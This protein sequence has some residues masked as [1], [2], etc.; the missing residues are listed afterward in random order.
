[1]SLGLPCFR[2]VPNSHRDLL[3]EWDQH[4][5]NT[6]DQ[7]SNCCPVCVRVSLFVSFGVFS[8]LPGLHGDRKLF[9]REFRQSSACTTLRDKTPRRIPSLREIMADL[10]RRDAQNHFQ[11][12]HV[13]YTAAQARSVGICFSHL[14]PWLQKKVPRWSPKRQRKK[15]QQTGTQKQVANLAR[16]AQP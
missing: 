4:N 5:T 2:P 7:I 11:V 10:K 8:M 1:M 6:F 3:A 14:A 12:Q 16:G 15:N 13:N 9:H